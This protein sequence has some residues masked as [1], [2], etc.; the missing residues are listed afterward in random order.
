MINPLN[1]EVSQKLLDLCALSPRAV[2]YIKTAL[3]PPT[4]GKSDYHLILYTELV[5]QFIIDDVH[6][7]SVWEVETTACPPPL[8]YFWAF[9]SGKNKPVKFLTIPT[10]IVPKHLI[11]TILYYFNL[12]DKRQMTF[13][14]LALRG[15]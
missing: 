13:R 3:P 15:I 6:R 8:L 5:N 14:F 7:S 11:K 12:L 10:K 2:S 4:D 1:T 9:T